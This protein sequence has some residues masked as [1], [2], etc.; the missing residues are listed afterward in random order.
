MFVVAGLEVREILLVW[1]E[2]VPDF[3]NFR[4]SQFGD[5]RFS[6]T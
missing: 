4:A 1:F 6:G 5:L 3:N 2:A